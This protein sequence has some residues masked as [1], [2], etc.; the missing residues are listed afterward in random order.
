MAKIQSRIMVGKAQRHSHEKWPIN[1]FV[2]F[3]F[4]NTKKKESKAKLRCDESSE[5]FVRAPNEIVL[6]CFLLLLYVS[7][8]I[9]VLAEANK[10]YYINSVY[11]KCRK[12]LSPRWAFG[13]WN[14]WLCAGEFCHI[15]PEK[16][17]AIL[18]QRVR[19]IFIFLSLAMPS[20][21]NG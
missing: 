20:V 2:H 11:A 3:A 9:N 1:I 7:C 8:G 4:R 16:K 14:T 19:I 18:Y 13:S 21:V 15:R 5:R 6:V 12:G 17:A 10:I